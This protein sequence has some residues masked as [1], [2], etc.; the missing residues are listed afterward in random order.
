[1]SFQ[2]GNQ[3]A[4][5]KHPKTEFKK[6]Q[7]SWN[8]GKKMSK[9]FCKRNS[10]IHKGQIPWNKKPKIRKICFVCKIEFLVIPARKNAAKFCSYK[11]YWKSL[12]ETKS[13]KNNYFWKSGKYKTTEGYILVY[14]PEHPF[15]TKDGYVREHRLVMEKYLGRYLT[16]KEV[17]HHINKIK[18]DNRIENFIL[19][20]H[21]GYHGWFHK[22][23]YCNP[24][25]I[26]FD[27]R[28]F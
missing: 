11:C 16:Q 25:G 23:G 28:K 22:N 10:I 14:N 2:K 15:C 24:K 6:G 4:K 13:G 18:N 20:K 17:V 8:K 19:F 9:E 3:F 27:G 1:M 7:T 26:I 5:G 21:Q 12:E